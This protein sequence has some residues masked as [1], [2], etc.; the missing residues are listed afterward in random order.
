MD[1]ET[2]DLLK[3]GIIAKAASKWDIMIADDKEV[4]AAEE[5]TLSPEDIKAITEISMALTDLMWVFD[6]RNKEHV[7]EYINLNKKK[8]YHQLQKYYN[9]TSAEKLAKEKLVYLYMASRAKKNPIKDEKIARELID[10]IINMAQANLQEWKK[11][12]RKFVLYLGT[13]ESINDCVEYCKESWLDISKE[14]ISYTIKIMKKFYKPM[15]DQKATP[16][17]TPEQAQNE[18]AKLYFETSLTD[19]TDHNSII[20]LSESQWEEFLNHLDKKFEA[21]ELQWDW[22]MPQ[23]KID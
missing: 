20:D 5:H 22:E 14:N 12:F 9:D 23:V 15:L 21:G 18:L 10:L 2:E 16:S 3:Q 1:K 13:R 6:I 4:L 17:L 11:N 7:D 8:M 19:I